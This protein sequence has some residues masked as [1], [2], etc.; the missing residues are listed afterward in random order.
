MFL[1]FGQIQ[2]GAKIGHG[3]PL[4]QETSSSATATYQM[5]SSDVEA[6]GKK[7]CY[8]WFH[9]EVKFL[10]RFDV[11]LDFIILPYFYAISMDFYAVLKVLNLHLFCVISMF[12]SGRM[13]T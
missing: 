10:M 5:H 6:C 4:L 12:V 11:F 8:F 3:D 7:C 1:F 9:S 2:G 13:L